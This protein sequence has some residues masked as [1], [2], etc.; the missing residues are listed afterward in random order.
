MGPRLQYR[1]NEKDLVV[2][3]N[4]FEGL[5]GGRRI[6]L[7][8]RMLIER[9][10]ETGLMAMSQGVG[11]TASIVAQMIAANEISAKGLLSP[12]IHIPYAPFMEQLAKRGIVVD[13]EEEELSSVSL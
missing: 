8:L 7:T 10:L 11:Y 5:A 1:D 12:A 9:D 13:E 4:I 3:L 6:R 2:M